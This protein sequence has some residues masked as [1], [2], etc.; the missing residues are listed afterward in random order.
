MGGFSVLS[1]GPLETGWTARLVLVLSVALVMNI[2]RSHRHPVPRRLLQH[3]KKRK[4]KHAQFHGRRTTSTVTIFSSGKC[5]QANEAL[6]K[7][8]SFSIWAKRL[9]LILD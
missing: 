9:L 5:F 4:Y 6:H 7:T 1:G 3:Q 8:R 2:S